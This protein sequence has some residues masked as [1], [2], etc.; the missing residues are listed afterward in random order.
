MEINKIVLIARQR[1][2]TGFFS[3]VLNGHPN[4]YFYPEVFLGRDY[5][6]IYSFFRYYKNIVDRD[7][8]YLTFRDRAKVIDAYLDHIFTEEAY[9]K[10]RDSDHSIPCKSLQVIG[11]D[12]K[13]TDFKDESA[14]LP[15]LRQK[16]V[17]IIH[18]IRKNHL[19]QLI[20]GYHNDMK[21]K[22]SRKAHMTYSPEQVKIKIPV[23]QNLL[24]KIKEIESDVINFRKVI[25]QNFEYLEVFYEDLVNTTNLDNTGIEASELDRIYRFLGVH[26]RPHDLQTNLRKTN[27]DKLSD[28]VENYD[29]VRNTLESAELRYLDFLSM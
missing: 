20:S 14:I 21:K 24:S 29:D 11:L 9:L 6:E 2:G 3:T 1:S 13:Y 18:L 12:I 28:I 7:A 16:N 4:I 19:K 10:L 22:L 15:L 8:K 27:S 17:K 23:G 26:E 5:K 25:N